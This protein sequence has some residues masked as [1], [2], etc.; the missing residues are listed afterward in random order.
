MPGL[1]HCPKCGRAIAYICHKHCCC[2]SC[3]DCPTDRYVHV[4][5]QLG[6]TALARGEQ[7]G[8]GAA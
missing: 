8:K 1:K 2:A 3:C 4:E 7:Q 5:T 6:S